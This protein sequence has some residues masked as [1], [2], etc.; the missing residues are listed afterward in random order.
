[1]SSVPVF[2]GGAEGAGPTGDGEVPLSPFFS[3]QPVVINERPKAMAAVHLIHS[4]FIV[5]P[6]FFSKFDI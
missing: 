5:N 1:V 4:D 6:S 3:P 2:S